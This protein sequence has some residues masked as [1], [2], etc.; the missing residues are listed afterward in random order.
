MPSV[1][2]LFLPLCPGRTSL[3]AVMHLLGAI[4]WM[5]LVTP[6]SV[7]LIRPPVERMRDEILCPD[8]RIREIIPQ[9]LFSCRDAITK[10]LGEVYRNEVASSCYDAGSTLLRRNGPQGRTPSPLL[11][12]AH[13]SLPGTW[14]SALAETLAGISA[15]VFGGCVVWWMNFSAVRGYPGGGVTGTRWPWVTTWVFGAWWRRL[16]WSKPPVSVS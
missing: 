10:A 1:L 12:M 13:R 16:R 11:S 3:V 2:H 8:E 9:K 7:A 4:G 5:N 14:S 6:V 15:P